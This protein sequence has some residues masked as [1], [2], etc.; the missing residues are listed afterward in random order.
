MVCK[1]CGGTGCDTAKR[2]ANREAQEKLQYE[3]LKGLSCDDLVQYALGMIPS[4]PNEP[5]QTGLASPGATETALK[6]LKERGH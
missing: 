4:N 3:L 1:L 6:I 2:K 5:F